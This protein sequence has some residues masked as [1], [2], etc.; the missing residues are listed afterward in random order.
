[1]RL[2]KKQRRVEE[3]TVLVLHCQ[4]RYGL[5]KRQET[6]LLA[7]L[8]QFPDLPGKMEVQQAVE[9]VEAMGMGVR[10]VYRSIRRKHIFTHVQWNMHGVYLEVSRQGGDF[11]WLTAEEIN[12][13][14]ALPTAY[15]LFWDEI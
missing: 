2:P 13:Q 7:G 5:K 12:T 3:K 6:G 1:V 14:A 9:A 4:G 11:S 8:W 10:Q 15:R